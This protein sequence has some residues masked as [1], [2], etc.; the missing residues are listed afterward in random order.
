MKKK[1]NF[2]GKKNNGGRQINFEK[3]IMEVD[4]L[5]LKKKWRSTKKF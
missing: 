5:I 1:I 3:K 2:K 4:K